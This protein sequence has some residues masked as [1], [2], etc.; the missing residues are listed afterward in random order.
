MRGR[1][2]DVFKAFMY[3]AF[4][5]HPGSGRHG[6]LYLILSECGTLKIGRAGDVSSRFNDLSASSGCWLRLLFSLRG[7]AFREKALHSIFGQHRF[8]HEWFNFEGALK[9]WTLNFMSAFSPLDKEYW[10]RNLV[11][12]EYPDHDVFDFGGC[13]NHFGRKTEDM[14]EEEQ[15]AKDHAVGLVGCAQSI[16]RILCGEFEHKKYLTG[17]EAEIILKTNRRTIDNMIK[18]KILDSFPSGVHARSRR[19]ALSSTLT[20]WG[21]ETKITKA[22]VLKYLLNH[23]E[24]GGRELVERETAAPPPSPV[25]RSF[26]NKGA[27]P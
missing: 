9:S 24:F 8:H 25:A 10:K 13:H 18:L 7:F 19:A 22:S 15:R 20:S 23:P 6:H 14:Q 11:G 5:Y 2:V 1:D 4:E 16:K 21:W 17:D 27:L 26:I 3:D 12:I